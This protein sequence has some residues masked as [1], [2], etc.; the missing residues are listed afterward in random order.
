MSAWRV[1]MTDTE[2]PTG[3][4]P[5]CPDQGDYTKHST[6]DGCMKE[7]ADTSGV[8]DCCPQPYIETWNETTAATLAQV[9]TASEAQVC[10]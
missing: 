8:Y 10:P 4:A 9:L 2:G 3:V 7:P 1:I 5:V 6:G